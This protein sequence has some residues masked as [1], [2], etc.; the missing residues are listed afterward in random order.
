VRCLAAEL[1]GDTLESVGGGLLDLAPDLGTARE[2]YLVDIRMARERCPG[3][4]T[5]AP[6]RL[7]VRIG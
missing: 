3:D 5:E 7:V 6:D 1:Q 4:F 2:A